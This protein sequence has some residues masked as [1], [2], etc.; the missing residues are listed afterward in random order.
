MEQKIEKGEDPLMSDACADIAA[1][2]AESPRPPRKKSS[3]PFVCLML[4]IP[5]PII[6][7]R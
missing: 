7:K 4:Q 2:G 3:A 1:T 5:I 6:P